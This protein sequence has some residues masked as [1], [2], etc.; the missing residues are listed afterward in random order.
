MRNYFYILFVVFTCCN[1]VSEKETAKQFVVVLG[2]AQ[3]AGYPQ[4]GCTKECCKAVSEGKETKKHVV[5]LALLDAT[6]NE[7][8][9]FEATPDITS[10]LSLLQKQYHLQ[11]IQPTA[12]FLTHAHIGHYTGLMYFGREAMNSSSVPVYT[13][14]RLDS[15]LRNNGPWNQLVSVKNIELQQM[16]KDSSVQ[17][18]SNIKVTAL[19]VP[20]RDEF[21][22]TA[23]F[24]IQTQN[25]KLLFIPDIDKWQK[26]GKSIVDLIHGVDYA[27]LDATFYKDGELPNRNMSEVPHPFVQESMELFKGMSA[28]DKQKVYFIHFNHTNPLLK[29]NGSAAKEVKQKGFNIAEEGMILNME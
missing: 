29:T 26:W 19:Q 6:K 15:F 20:H 14:P 17:L 5:S 9:L 1:Q 7:Y 25:K 21:S 13:L 4:L 8:F 11:S 12:V 27:L 23:G 28:A 22:E 10:Q 18:S 3:D 2:V 16:K 24:I